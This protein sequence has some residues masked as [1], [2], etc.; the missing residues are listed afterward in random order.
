LFNL[1]NLI[2]RQYA[3]TAQ[4][5]LGWQCPNPLNQE[6]ALFKKAE[7]WRRSMTIARMAPFQLSAFSISAFPFEM[8]LFSQGDKVRCQLE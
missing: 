7:M 4:E 5:I 1:S 2:G 6:C 8:D 3:K